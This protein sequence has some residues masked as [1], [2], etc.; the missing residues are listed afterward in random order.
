MCV[1]QGA[2]GDVSSRVSP[3]SNLLFMSVQFHLRI[4]S[5]I[6]QKTCSALP[7]TNWIPGQSYSVD[8]AATSKAERKCELA[9]SHFLTHEQAV[10]DF[11]LKL[12]VAKR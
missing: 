6:Y 8:A 9:L 3:F 10:H 11:E 7:I 2:Q 12:G 4:S 1:C 5:Q